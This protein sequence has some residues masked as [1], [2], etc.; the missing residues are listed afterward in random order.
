M[1]YSTG[2]SLTYTNQQLMYGSADR[3]SAITASIYN[4]ASSELDSMGTHSESTLFELEVTATMSPEPDA[5]LGSQYEHLKT[6]RNKQIS[7]LI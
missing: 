5:V 7:I 2:T 3:S 4:N 6:Q 1:H